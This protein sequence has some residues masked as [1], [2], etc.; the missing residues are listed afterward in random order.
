MQKAWESD[1]TFTGFAVRMFEFETRAGMYRD[2]RRLRQR[3]LLD[4]T[5]VRYGA[6]RQERGAEQSRETRNGTAGHDR[7]PRCRYDRPTSCLRAAGVMARTMS[8]M[9][10]FWTSKPSS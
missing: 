5:R 8:R 1:N 6:R 7:F 4:H 2:V 10:P 3:V 9:N